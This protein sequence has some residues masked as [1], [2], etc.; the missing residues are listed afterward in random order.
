MIHYSNGPLRSCSSSSNI[1]RLF[2]VHAA[3]QGIEAQTH[4]GFLF[5]TH[6]PGTAPVYKTEEEKFSKKRI[7]FPF[8]FNGCV[9]QDGFH[10]YHVLR[11]SDGVLN[12]HRFQ[13][14]TM[15]ED[16]CSGLFSLS[17]HLSVHLFT[18]GTYLP[19]ITNN[20]GIFPLD[21]G[22]WI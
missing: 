22:L 12:H 17:N 16:F 10:V 13:L 15:K 14:K 2:C 1:C 4:Y 8:H 19:R 7:F 5:P 20:F 6:R 11:T 21:D 18:T 3:S 9:V